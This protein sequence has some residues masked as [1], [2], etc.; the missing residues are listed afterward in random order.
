MDER[1]CPFPLLHTIHVPPSVRSNFFKPLCTYRRLRRSSYSYFGIATPPRLIRSADKDANT[2]AATPIRNIGVT[3]AIYARRIGIRSDSGSRK[4]A[5][6]LE[7]TSVFISGDKPVSKRSIPLCNSVEK[8]A[9]LALYE[10][11]LLSS[12]HKKSF[13]VSR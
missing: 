12:F 8:I 9:W 6:R 13:R 5:L 3:A 4:T 10:R 2:L 1:P 11:Q 7:R